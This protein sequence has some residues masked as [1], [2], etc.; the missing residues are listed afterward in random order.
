MAIV[1]I[2]DVVYDKRLEK[3]IEIKNDG[4][5]HNY[6]FVEE[7]FVEIKNKKEKIMEKQ[8]QSNQVVKAEPKQ[9]KDVGQKAVENMLAQVESFATFEAL[10]LTNKEKHFA[11]DAILSINKELANRQLE[12]KDIDIVKNAVPQQIKA[13]A[14]LGLRFDNGELYLDIRNNKNNK[15]NMKDL[16][17]KKQYQ[18]IEKE[19]IKFCQKKVVRF[20]DGIVLKGE[21]L[22]VQEDF[23]TGLDKI[24]GHE[25]KENRDVN[26]WDDIESVYKIAYVEEEINGEK[27]MVQYVAI[28]DRNRLERAYKASPTGDKG[29]WKQDTKLMVLKT[30]TWVLYNNVLRPF[31]NIPIELSKDWQ[32]TNDEMDWGTSPKEV[33]IDE[34][35]FDK[36][37]VV[38]YDDETGELSGPER[39]SLDEAEQETLFDGDAP[40]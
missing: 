6:S 20:K 7:E 1:K 15:N 9:I 35:D 5:V 26:N 25:K 19:I 12:W 16:T 14:R 3:E 29:V 10:P 28:V 17:I 23:E 31:I 33:E 38:E 13:H 27:K 2:G 24:V 36:G 22:L 8:G 32:R 40:F 4:Q 11:V 30:A 21:K 39:T 34:E 18:G 37:N